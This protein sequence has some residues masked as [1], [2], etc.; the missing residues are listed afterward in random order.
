[1]GGVKYLRSASHGGKEERRERPAAARGRPSATA[2]H[3]ELETGSL[4]HLPPAAPA[5]QACWPSLPRASP[6]PLEGRVRRATHP[7]MRIQTSGAVAQEQVW[8]RSDREGYTFT[9]RTEMTQSPATAKN[10]T[11]LSLALSPQSFLLTWP[12]VSHVSPHCPSPPR[13]RYPAQGTHQPGSSQDRVPSQEDR[14][15]EMRK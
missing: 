10:M 5:A 8:G 2:Q 14:L 15:A 3:G 11:E 7:R 13:S 12:Q 9:E 1:M 6:A 4:L